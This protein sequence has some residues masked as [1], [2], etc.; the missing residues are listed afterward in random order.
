MKTRR[1]PARCYRR[2]KTPITDDFAALARDAVVLRHGSL[3]PADKSLTWASFRSISELLGLPLLKVKRICELHAADQDLL[4]A[5]GPRKR[6]PLWQLQAQHFAYLIAPETLLA[7]Q[8]HSIRARCRL[9]HRQFPDK[10]I[11]TSCLRK[12]YK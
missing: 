7:W 6:Q 5:F 1:F 3:R 8:A 9:F 10:R 12:L 4:L 11:S 2:R